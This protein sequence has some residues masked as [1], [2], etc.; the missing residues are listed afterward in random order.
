MRILLGRHF[1]AVGTGVVLS[2]VAAVAVAG[3]DEASRSI[4]SQANRWDGF[5]AGLQGGYSWGDTDA[6]ALWG[7][8]GASET[9][10]YGSKG[11]LIGMYGGYMRRIDQVLLG[12]ETDFDIA[13]V[14]G[15]GNS[16]VAARQTTHVDWMGSLRARIGIA[17]DSSLLY[18]TGGIAYGQLQSE[19]YVV[20]GAMP[21]ASNHELM[22]GW[23]AGGGIEQALTDNIA[24]R[25]E[26]RYTD[27]GKT[28]Y[29]DPT[30]NMKETLKLDSHAVRA[31][32]GVKF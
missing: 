5:Y 11:G 19:Q 17:I 10:S 24:L 2:L 27:F 12:I 6:D 31:G 16:T 14:D 4:Y 32:I 1:V 7:P 20:G 30:L 23:T 15:A 26:Y 28:S 9:F 8:V 3:N 13:D 18:V 29:F 21:Y 22:T 25:L